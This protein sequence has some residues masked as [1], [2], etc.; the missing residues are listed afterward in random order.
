[1]TVIEG[2]NVDL[3]EPFPTSEIRRMRAW[4]RCYKSIVESDDSPQTEAEFQQFME[5]LLAR[6]RSWGVIDKH[7]ALAMKE[8]VRQGMPVEDAQQKVAGWAPSIVGGIIFEPASL[9]NGY[10]HVASSRKAWGSGFMDEAGAE[11]IKAVFAIPELLRVSAYTLV[12]NFPAKAL[13][14]RLGFGFEGV[15]SDMVLRDGEPQAIAHFGLTRSNWEQKCQQHSQSLLPR[16][17][18]E[19]SSEPSADLVSKDSNL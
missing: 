18:E 8:L 6:S 16:P 10:F 14:R 4:L 3:I 11:A 17:S 15:L 9:R 12:R 13:A 7:N 5:A 2:R 1:M 19:V